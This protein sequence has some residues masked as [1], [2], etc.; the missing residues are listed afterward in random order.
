MRW[1]WKGADIILETEKG[2]ELWDVEQLEVG[3]GRAENLDCKKL[4]KTKF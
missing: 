4:L 1:K 2:E 3:P